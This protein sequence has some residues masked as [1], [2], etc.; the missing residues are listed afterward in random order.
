[1]DNE[2][3]LKDTLAGLTEDV[4]ESVEYLRELGVEFLSAPRADAVSIP[5]REP[6]AQAHARAVQ[7]RQAP[8]RAESHAQPTP[9]PV[10]PAL[11]RNARAGEPGKVTPLPPSPFSSA[12]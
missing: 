9:P 3:S 11:S 1:M 8:A 10:S 4:A 12:P 6:D 5:R 2:S 7:S